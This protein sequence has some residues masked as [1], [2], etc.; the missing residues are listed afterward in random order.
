VGNVSK[1]TPHNIDAVAMHKEARYNDL[2]G[3]TFRDGLQN[4]VRSWGQAILQAREMWRTVGIARGRQKIESVQA[5][6]DPATQKRSW[7]ATIP[8]TRKVGLTWV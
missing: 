1:A 8:R 2:R 6:H 7:G 4:D 5:M 3:N